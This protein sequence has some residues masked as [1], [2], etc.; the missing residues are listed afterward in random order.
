MVV[1]A[2]M[3]NSIGAFQ[4][5]I[6][7][8]QLKD[9]PPGTVGWIFS[10][11][12]ALTF[13]CGAQVGPTF[14]A[15]GPRLLVLVGSISL[16]LSMMLLGNCREL[17]HFI[18]VFGVLGGLG[19]AL[20][21]VPA[22]SVI[23]HYF[24]VKRANASGLAATGSSFGGIM[25]PLVLQSLYPKLG[26]AWATR[27]LGFIFVALLILA[28]ILIRSRLPSRA[29][30]KVELLPQLGTFRSLPYS[31]LVMGVFLSEWG[32]FI[33]INYISAYALDHGL[34]TA[35][36]YQLLALLNAGSFFGRWIP[37]YAADRIGRFNMLILTITLCLVSTLAIWLPAGSSK[38][39]VVTYAVVFGFASG[40]N[41]SLTPP[42]IG[43]LCDTEDYGKYY[44]TCYL[45]VSIGYVNPRLSPESLR[46][47]H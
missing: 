10:L 31:L 12:V 37:G 30:A 33:P 34:P 29:L 23:S 45:M 21:L 1:S 5:Y 43:Q 40:S 25:I 20:T 6:G 39:L 27:I 18:I 15:K 17:W 14:D 26:F 2:G 35:L 41:I 16:I 13:F 9:H 47:G 22:V 32:L 42:C 24:L 19:T 28:N 7:A 46:V 11:Y 4:A 38:P 3:M 8:H 44:S 36:S